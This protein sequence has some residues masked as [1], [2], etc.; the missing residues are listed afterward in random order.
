MT[1]VE[2]VAA[3]LVENGVRYAFGIGGHGNTPLVHAFRPYHCTGRLRVVD[4]H[5]EAV[6]AHA[7]TALKW[8]YGIESVVSTSI[9]P[10]WL[11]TLTGQNTAMSIGYGFLVLAG[12]K[13][14]AYEGPNMQQIMRD[15]QFE[16]GEWCQERVK[17]LTRMRN[18]S[19]RGLADCKYEHKHSKHSGCSST[20]SCGESAS[21][22]DADD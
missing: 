11:N 20:I 10:G 16:G 13:T 21:D 3:F 19:N 22:G 17:K 7:A 12:D 5:H 9:G 14:T 1:I 4:V 2:A 8:A 18:W 15:G 6:A